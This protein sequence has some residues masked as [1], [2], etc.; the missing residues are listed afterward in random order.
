MP[1]S[2]EQQLTRRERQIMDILHRK[3]EASVADVVA[4]LPQPPTHTAVRAF[5]SI[6]ERKG[7]VR[8]RKDGKRFIYR[9]VRSRRRAA[10]D[11]LNRVLDVFFDDS[12]GDAVAAHLA[13][14]STRIDRKELDRLAD[15][16]KQ[17]RTGDESND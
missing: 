15:I 7:H 3:S 6:L 12:L 5:L 14:P 11:A 13:D 2:N 1:R 9:P 8:R 10:R 4:E 16:I 17:A